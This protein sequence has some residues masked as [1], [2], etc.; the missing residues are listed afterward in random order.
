MRE[1][2]TV[3]DHSFKDLQA[4]GRR[5]RDLRFSD[6]D[7]SHCDLSDSQLYDCHFE[8]CR[9]SNCNLSNLSLEGVHLEDVQL[10]T[11]KALGLDW[12]KTSYL[13]GLGA[14]DSNLDFNT[15][16]GLEVKDL[17]LEGCLLRDAFFQDCSLPKARFSDSNLTGANFEDCKLRQADFTGTEGFAALLSR[18]DLRQAVLPLASALHLLKEFQIIV[19]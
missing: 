14:K 12:S 3:E 5:F 9:F 7:F 19:R 8:N 16:A 1:R 2:R 18:N 17:N 11:C 10:T 15:F 13:R 4:A 6:C